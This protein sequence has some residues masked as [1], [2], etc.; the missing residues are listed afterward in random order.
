MAG[1]EDK[2]ALAYTTWHTDQG[3]GFDLRVVNA[4]GTAGPV[5]ASDPSSNAFASPTWSPDGKMIAF[6]GS[7]GGMGGVFLVSAAGGQ[8]N[9]LVAASTPG[10]DRLPSRSPGG[11]EI[12]YWAGGGGTQAVTLMGIHPDGSG[13]RIIAGPFPAVPVG[14]GYEQGK[15]FAPVSWSPEAGK[16]RSRTAAWARSI[17]CPPMAARRPHS[18]PSRLAQTPST[19]PSGHEGDRRL[20]NA[21]RE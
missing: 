7:Y 17:R 16:S 12:A 14:G 3:G 6:S 5:V 18:C 2:R 20:R 15:G 10:A 8:V 4:D 11:N 13:G 9:Q 21:R 19:D 1:A